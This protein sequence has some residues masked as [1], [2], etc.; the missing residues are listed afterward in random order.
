SPSASTEPWPS[1]LYSALTFAFCL[2][3][4]FTLAFDLYRAPFAFSFRC[5]FALGFD[6]DSAL[7][8]S[9]NLVNEA[10]RV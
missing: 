6:L 8:F 3:G 9:L 1:P 7:T 5:T 10:L 4:A 2:R